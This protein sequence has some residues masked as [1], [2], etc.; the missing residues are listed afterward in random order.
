MFALSFCYGQ[1]IQIINGIIVARNALKIIPEDE[2]KIAAYIA[3]RGQRSLEVENW[4]KAE[5]QN[6]LLTKDLREFRDAYSRAFETA[7]LPKSSKLEW[8]MNETTYRVLHSLN[9]SC[10]SR[11][12]KELLD[13]LRADAREEFT[14]YYYNTNLHTIID[15]NRAA[16][17]LDSKVRHGRPAGNNFSYGGG[18]RSSA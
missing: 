5:N 13:R 8:M 4:R 16:R 3:S 12:D 9:F 18:P 14:R 11:A 7:K 17:A 1:I 15:F 2:K 6:M 10:T